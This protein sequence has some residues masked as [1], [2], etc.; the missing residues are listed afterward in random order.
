MPYFHFTAKARRDLSPRSICVDLWSSFQKAF[1]RTLGCV[2]MPDHFH[3]LLETSLP[4]HTKLTLAHWMAGFARKHF[5]GQSLWNPIAPPTAIHDFHHL[6]RQVRYVHLNPCRRELVRDP[7]AWEWSTHREAVGAAAS[8]W[9]DVGT[10]MKAFKAPPRTFKEIFHQYVSADPSVDVAG[11]SLPKASDP[12]KLIAPASALQA[13]I[14]QAGRGISGSRATRRQIVMLGNQM[15]ARPAVISK[16]AGLSPR[17]VRHILS[18]PMHERD[19]A[20]L[21]AAVLLLSAP[22]RFGI[23]S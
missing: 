11:T 6:K 9:L 4:E 7:L 16:A 2:L 15:G 8:D 3:I 23:R 13:A 19:S 18:R 12:E 10:L 5:L 22:D 17:S 14:L 1:P 20:V 21:K